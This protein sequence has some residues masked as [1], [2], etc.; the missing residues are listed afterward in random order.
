MKRLIIF[1]LLL[2]MASCVKDI[3]FDG[4]QSDPLLVVNGVQQ[5]GQPAC[6]FIE[7]SVFFL[8]DQVDCRVKGLEVDLFV[9]GNFKESLKVRDTITLEYIFNYCEGQYVLREG[10]RLRFE[11]RSDEFEMAVAEVDL[12]DAPIV[13]SLDTVGIDYELGMIEFEVTID[14]PVNTD[15]YNLC[16]YNSLGIAEFFS[17]DPVFADPLNLDPNSLVGES[18]DYYGTGFYNVFPDTYFNGKVYTVKFSSYYWEDEYAETFWL[19]VNRV[20]EHLYRYSKTY[21]VY[22]ESNPNSILGMFSE[23]VQVYS[24]VQNAVGVVCGQSESIIKPIVITSN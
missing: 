1:L 17:G 23:P 11:V 21:E 9:N 13:L 2:G 6:L 18:S 20:D 14:D 4:E 12:P 15:F 3:E 7:K 16:M 10:D 5:V 22:Q 8:D 24:N 19:E